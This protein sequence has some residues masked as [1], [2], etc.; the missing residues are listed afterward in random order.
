MPTPN[1]SIFLFRLFGVRVFLHYSW[2]L[3]AVFQVYYAFQD[4]KTFRNEPHSLAYHAFLYICLFLIVLMHEF[5]HS[6]ACKSV[7]GTSD[8]IVLFPLGG[9]SYVRPP[10]RAGA[11]LW[12]IAAGPLVNVI[13]VPVTFGALVLTNG[14][15]GT[16]FHDFLFDLAIINLSLLIFNMLPIYPLDGGQIFRAML[17]FI[18]GRGVS[19]VIAAGTGLAG[20]VIGGLAMLVLGQFWLA[21]LG[22][23]MAMQAYAG[24]RIGLAM[25]KLEQA[26]RRFEVRCPSCLMNPP[27]MPAW[28]CACGMRLDT[29]EHGLRC[30]GCGTAFNNTVC[31][32]CGKDSPS[33]LWYSAMGTQSP[34][35][36][37][38]SPGQGPVRVTVEPVR[39]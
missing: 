23:F 5:G 24:L 10:E 29:F 15:G 26:P 20:S 13:L 27:M 22:G 33:Y 17:W 25:L 37:P 32:F 38:N 1:G 18:F 11:L 31:P 4:G 9:V 34:T 21:L 8:T 16:A 3:V 2:I 30:P 28:R 6:L 36:P 19:L 7:G 39:S 14:I 35:D 12:S